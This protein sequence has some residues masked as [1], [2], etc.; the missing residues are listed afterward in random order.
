MVT[1]G[2]EMPSKLELIHLSDLHVGPSARHKNALR[3]RMLVARICQRYAGPDA[4]AILISGDLT[5]N[6]TAPELRQAAKILARFKEAGFHLLVCPG[7]HDVG[8]KGNTFSPAA[9]VNFQ[10]IIL[11]ELLEVTGARTATNRMHTFYPRV[12]TLRGVAC[13]GL[14]TANQEDHLASGRIGEQQC[15]AL[16]SQLAQIPAGTPI[17]VYMHHHVFQWVHAMRLWDSDDLLRTL[18][19]RVT[20]LCF[21]HKHQSRVWLPGSA[22]SRETGVELLVA[23]GSSTVPEKRSRPPRF[24]YVRM[25]T[26]HQNGQP[27]HEDLCL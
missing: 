25:L 21:G 19:R 12:E 7:N 8:P 5:N 4:P 14:D 17:V 16:Q 20:L 18:G 22:R 24:P 27:T 13:I 6:G 11:G 10:Q 1:L 9:Q 2:T 26:I 15:S 23:S 3:L